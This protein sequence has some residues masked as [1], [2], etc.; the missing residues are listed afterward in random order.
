M[1]ALSLTTLYENLGRSKT[2]VRFRKIGTAE[3]KVRGIRL[4]SATPGT[5]LRQDLLYLVPPGFSFPIDFSDHGVRSAALI[6]VS[7]L[8]GTSENAG[9][10]VSDSEELRILTGDLYHVFERFNQWYDSVT[11]ALLHSIP[12]ESILNLCAEV[13]PDTVY[14]TD[15]GMKMY[16]H[17]SPTLMPEISAIWR[18]QVKYRYMP[19][20]VMNSLLEKHEL[21][22]IN[23]HR[24]A[25][26]LPTKTFNLPYTCRNI[27]CEGVL[28]ARIFIVSIYSNPR[29]T[30]L[31]IADLLGNLLIPYVSDHSE[32]LTGA[33]QIYD[34]FFRDILDERLVDQILIQQQI[35]IFGWNTED[36]YAI[37]VI[38]ISSLTEQQTAPLISFLQSQRVDSRAFTIRRH[39][40]NIYHPGNEMPLEKIKEPLEKILHDSSCT[41]ALSKP[42][43]GFRNL[44]VYYRQTS[45]ILNYSRALYPLKSLF[46]Q[47]E[48]GLYSILRACT[49]NH[50]AYELCSSRALTLLEYDQEHHTEFLETLYQYLL[51]NCSMVKAADRLY[52][53]RNTMSYRMEKIHRLINFDESDSSQRLYLLLSAC[54]LRDQLRQNP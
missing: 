51:E 8:L 18:Y 29:Q 27:F 41:G 20:N 50:S 52:I 40:I 10:F 9:F 34:D 33:G 43:R 49:E 28:R 5:E 1:I 48:M 16:A 38:D 13:T 2:F 35:E 24:Q 22:E 45:E 7:G 31:D 23:R 4:L 15:A 53:H 11:S 36:V 17:S 12:L 26:T 25:F 30:H 21:E 3:I 47:E 42:F 39:L 19:I 14:V 54:L 37:L 44:P 6:G 32:Y 46:A